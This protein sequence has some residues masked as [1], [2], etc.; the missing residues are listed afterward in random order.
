MIRKYR[1]QVVEPRNLDFISHHYFFRPRNEVKL[2]RVEDGEV[3][4][5]LLP[6]R[7]NL[8]R[9]DVIELDQRQVLEGVYGP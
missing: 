2:E 3:L 6:T 8:K 9:G 5:I 7:W 1:V 4:N